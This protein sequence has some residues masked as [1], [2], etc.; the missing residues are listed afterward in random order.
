[1]TNH[2]WKVTIITTTPEIFPGALD[3]SNVGRSLKNKIWDLEIIAIDKFK[4]N[5]KL[6]IDGPPS[7][8]GPG[9]ILRAD[10]VIPIIMNIKSKGD[11]RPIIIPAPRGI[12]YDQSIAKSLILEDGLII[13]C[14]RFEGVDQRIVEATGA[15]ELSIGDYILTNGDI[16]AINIIDSCVRLIDGVINS[17]ESIDSES[18][19]NNLL[20]YPQYT[21]PRN[22]NGFEIPQVLLEGNHKDIR[23]WRLK[24]SM[25]ITKKHRP[26]LIK[27]YKKN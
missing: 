21:L 1:M 7:G 9:M 12:K 19:E 2:K 8:G 5:K 23:D 15:T 26:D 20:E 13:V 27:K 6:K 10:V 22:Y 24:K 3:F 14:G 16:A 17:K 25:E 4:E 18:Y 11:N